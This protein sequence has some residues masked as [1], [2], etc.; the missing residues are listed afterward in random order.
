MKSG[1][2]SKL[3]QQGAALLMLLILLLLGSSY[4][5]LQRANSSPQGNQRA[6]EVHGSLAR[7]KE[8]L[9]A[10]AVA[11]ANRPGSLPC[12]DL[13]T[14]DA[15]LKNLPDDGKSDNFTRNDCPSYVGWLP[16]VTL[17]LPELT[18]ASGAR[19][20][21]VLARTLRDDESAQPINSNVAVNLTLDGN[22][23]IAALIIA[24]GSNIAGQSRPST[25]PADYLEGANADG[26]DAFVS[27]P[28]GDNFND[29]VIAITR[30]EL[31]A[32]TEQRV[33]NSIRTCLAQHTAATT[34]ETRTLPWPAP[35][36][37]PNK[38]GKAGSHFGNIPLTQPSEGPQKQLAAIGAQLDQA[39]SGLLAS[40]NPADR[41]NALKGLEITLT[42]S[43]NFADLL[44]TSAR[45]L[46]LG[47]RNNVLKFTTLS[48]TLASARLNGRISVTERN[49]IMTNYY[50]STAP[51]Q[52]LIEQLVDIGLDSFPNELERLQN[53][54][55]D[56]LRQGQAAPTPESLLILKGAL[57]NLVRLLAA[58]HTPIAGIAAISAQTQVSAAVAVQAIEL[59]LNTADEL[60]ITAA[61]DTSAM[62]LEQSRNLNTQISE[63]QRVSTPE[64]GTEHTTNL[65][66]SSLRTLAGQL[67]SAVSQ[68]ETT[69][70]LTQAAMVPYSDAIYRVTVDLLFWAEIIDRQNS[71]ISTQARRAPEA[72]KSSPNH[73]SLH[74]RSELALA[75]LTGTQGA[76]AKMQAYLDAPTKAGNEAA[77]S[78]AFANTIALLETTL[79]SKDSL[80]AATRSSAAQAFPTLWLDNACAFLQTG[81]ELTSWW[82]VNQWAENSFYQIAGR[83]PD[84]SPDSTSALTVNGQGS[85]EFVVIGAGAALTNQNRANLRAA[86]FFER[87]NGHPSR[88]GDAREPAR[89]LESA[90]PSRDFNDRLAY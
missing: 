11:D 43:R 78:N 17:D 66:E 18:D 44:F 82:H 84:G 22:S 31:I 12:P 21:Y 20:W 37:S 23:D 89:N 30:Q 68:F 72:S 36:S 7:A 40:N 24:P 28:I 47:A 16:W 81:S 56:A 73:E 29:L 60:H 87:G 2:H 86:D 5:Y 77:A 79:A 88:D 61:L 67:A 83:N 54:L 76:I 64:S 35:F 90:N 39:R 4:A 27:G 71:Q 33:I 70:N 9:I 69:T 51:L 55:A 49:T 34:N 80:L 45:N 14:N 57:D 46:A 1:H 41:L 10:R 38:R 53:P 6:A 8:A 85:Q 50:A 63:A 3:R 74:A 58:T 48:N 42:T 62:A 32:A 25:G 19:L 59:A 15:G 75:S 26:D 65:S 52:L 13:I